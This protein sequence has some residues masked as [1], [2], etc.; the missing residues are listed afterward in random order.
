MLIK[1]ND[2]RI[3]WDEQRFVGQKGRLITSLEQ[4]FPPN[5]SHEKLLEMDTWLSAGTHG[6]WLIQLGEELCTQE[7]TLAGPDHFRRWQSLAASIRDFVTLNPSGVS[8]TMDWVPVTA[9][10]LRSMDLA[11]RKEGR[12]FWA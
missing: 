10:Y 3:D 6:D 1:K 5:A 2:F 4:Y 11:L 12:L 8:G 7:P 9:W